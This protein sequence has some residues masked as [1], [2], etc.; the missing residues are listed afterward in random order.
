M[1][2]RLT[3]LERTFLWACINTQRPQQDLAAN[4]LKPQIV[5]FILSLMRVPGLV[6]IRESGQLEKNLC[7]GKG[8]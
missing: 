6:G 1:T 8:F 2:P 7:F 5:S 4:L 3:L